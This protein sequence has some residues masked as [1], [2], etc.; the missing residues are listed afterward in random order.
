MEFGRIKGIMSERLWRSHK[1]YTIIVTGRLYVNL[2]PSNWCRAKIE[3]SYADQNE[4]VL[5]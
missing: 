3:M 5:V 2:C 4:N 1:L